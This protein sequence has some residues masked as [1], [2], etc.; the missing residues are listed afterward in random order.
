MIVEFNNANNSHEISPEEK[1]SS[2]MIGWENFC[3]K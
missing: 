3:E 2:L 1:E